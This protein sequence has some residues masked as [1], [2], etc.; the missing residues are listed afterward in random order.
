MQKEIT[1]LFYQGKPVAYYVS[2]QKDRFEFQPTLSNKEAPS[3]EVIFTS[4]KLH[5]SGPV[6]ADLLEQAKEKVSSWLSSGLYKKMTGK[7]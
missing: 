7:D 4:D 5:P 1:T 3:F 2:L 6:D